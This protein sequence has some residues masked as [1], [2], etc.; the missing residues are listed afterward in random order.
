V[1]QIVYSGLQ[2]H[3]KSYEVVRSVIIPAIAEGRNVVTN[4]AGLKVDAIEQYIAT[5]YKGN[6]A[7]DPGLLVCVSNEDIIKPGFFPVENQNNEDVTVQGGDLV[8]IDEC[9]RFYATGDPLP[10]GHLTFFRMHRHF[11]DPVTGQCCDIGLIVQAIDDLQRK[12]RNT[13]EKS[14]LMQKHKDLGLDNRYVVSVYSGKN[15]NAKTFVQDYQHS[16]DPVIFA[17]YS[18]YSQSKLATGIEKSADKR[19]NFFSRPMIKY[20]MPLSVLAIGY[21]FYGL[22]GFFHPHDK[23]LSVA[24]ASTALTATNAATASTVAALAVPGL[25]TIWRLVGHYQVNGEYVFVLVDGSDRVRHVTPPAFKESA[26]EYEIALPSGEIVTQWSG[27]A[28]T[29]SKAP[30]V[31]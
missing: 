12:I 25:S 6:K 7:A 18:S 16:Y 21:A 19:G 23:S 17:L 27:A 29:Q 8:I 14:F 13:V 2:G 9:W 30:G 4:I 5:V 1:A 24:A 3:G 11:L 28:V 22:W 10:V 20:G 31:L 15:Q 26:G